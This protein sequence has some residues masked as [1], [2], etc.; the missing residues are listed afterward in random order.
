MLARRVAQQPVRA[1]QEGEHQ[2]A[3]GDELEEPPPCVFGVRQVGGALHQLGAAE[4]VTE[5]DDDEDEKQQIDET[6][7]GANGDDPERQRL[8]VRCGRRRPSDQRAPEVPGGEGRPEC[9][10]RQV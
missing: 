10:K 6:Q 8:S 9:G 3:G 4:E 5:L 2:A 7:R 1:E